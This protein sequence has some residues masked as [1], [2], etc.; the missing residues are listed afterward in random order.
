MLSIVVKS[1]KQYRPNQTKFNLVPILMTR[2]HLVF[3]GQGSSVKISIIVMP[4]NKINTI[5]WV[6]P[7]RCE[8]SSCRVF[9]ATWLL[10]VNLTKCQWCGSPTVGQPCYHLRTSVPSHIL[11]MFRLCLPYATLAKD[12]TSHIS[13]YDIAKIYYLD[14]GQISKVKV[15]TANIGT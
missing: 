11:Q 8:F 9:F 12:D 13:W 2:E 4:C 15:H 7:C 6:G 5:V 1:W 14:K 3:Q 10:L